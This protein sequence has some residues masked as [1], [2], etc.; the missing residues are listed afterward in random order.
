MA[1]ALARELGSFGIRVNS[2]CPDAV[3]EGSALWENPNYRE[4][5]CRRYNIKENEILE[6]YRKRSALKVNV[7]PE[8]VAETAL[9]LASD[10]SSKTTG[11]IISVDGGVA[12]VR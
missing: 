2:I 10:R 7:N 4:G 8:D 3:F 5:T 12:F 9:F 6:Y 1:R 11:S